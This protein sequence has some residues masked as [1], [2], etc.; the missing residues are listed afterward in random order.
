MAMSVPLPV[1]LSCQ[2]RQTLIFCRERRIHRLWDSGIFAGCV[3]SRSQLEERRVVGHG[4]L[5]PGW[6]NKKLYS[7]L[8]KLVLSSIISKYPN[9]K[10]GT[11]TPWSLK[12]DDVMVQLGQMPR[13]DSATKEGD[14]P[15]L[16]KRLH[17]LLAYGRER[18][19]HDRG[20]GAAGCL[21][22]CGLRILVQ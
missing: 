12:K 21:S 6:N 15:K 14:R 1:P 2:D 10:I 8:G 5:A 3:E 11:R 13:M 19:D 4:A 17:P 7:L 20:D 9:G 22:G 18:L 16:V